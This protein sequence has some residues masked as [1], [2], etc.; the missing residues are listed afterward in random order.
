MKFVA[1]TDIV[2]VKAF[3]LGLVRFD[4]Q[5]LPADPLLYA[6]LGLVA[7]LLVIFP[8]S[9]LL[10]APGPLLLADEKPGRRFAR[11]SAPRAVG[12]AARPTGLR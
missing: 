12:G 8:F 9:K 6:H 5:P 1:H 11:A 10:H 2:A 4:W 7:L 3:F